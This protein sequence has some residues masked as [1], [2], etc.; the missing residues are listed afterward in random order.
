[1]LFGLVLI[2]AVGALIVV[3]AVLLAKE[4]DYHRK[5][6]KKRSKK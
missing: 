2:S 4:F 1:M 5:E 3:Q 6:I